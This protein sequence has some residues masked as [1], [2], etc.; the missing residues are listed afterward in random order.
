MKSK[1]PVIP[2]SEVEA[3]LTIVLKKKLNV[4]GLMAIP[5]NDGQTENTLKAFQN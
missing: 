4:L 5:P 2:Y 1:N 3:F